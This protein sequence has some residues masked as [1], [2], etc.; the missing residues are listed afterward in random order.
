MEAISRRK[1]LN[2]ERSGLRGDV[3]GP[4]RACWWVVVPA[5]REVSPVAEHL[6]NPVRLKQHSLSQ[7]PARVTWVQNPCPSTKSLRG[8]G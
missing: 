3:E 1:A 7:L 2:L 8:F 4:P 6:S 5:R